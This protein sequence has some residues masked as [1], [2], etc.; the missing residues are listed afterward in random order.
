MHPSS[1]VERTVGLMW[2]L[3][4]LWSADSEVGIRQSDR[5]RATPTTLSMPIKLEI[6]IIGAKSDWQCERAFMASVTTLAPSARTIPDPDVDTEWTM[7]DFG[8]V[9]RQSHVY[10]FWAY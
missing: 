1:S 6:F 5:E 10:N 7:D 2:Q 8:P 4:P 9:D 3:E